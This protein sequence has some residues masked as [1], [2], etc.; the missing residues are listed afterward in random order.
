M[1]ERNQFLIADAIKIID[2][3][4]ANVPED[5]FG[6]KY[7][8]Q[9]EDGVF[10]LSMGRIGYDFFKKEKRPKF[11]LIEK[12]CTRFFRNGEVDNDGLVWYA[13]SPQVR[14][15][16]NLNDGDICFDVIEY[17]IKNWDTI[18]AKIL[19]NIDA[20]LVKKREEEY[21]ENLII[22]FNPQ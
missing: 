4:E 9:S 11:L 1:N 5:L 15:N 14:L 21:F 10:C 3:C 2:W 17:F 19:E 16:I 13:E 12:E 6:E 7:F 8:W 18:K 22:N 20:E